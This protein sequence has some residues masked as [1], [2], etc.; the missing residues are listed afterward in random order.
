MSDST[1][2]AVV[3]EIDEDSAFTEAQNNLVLLSQGKRHS[4]EMSASGSVGE[5]GD[6]RCAG[7]DVNGMRMEDDIGDL[8]RHRHRKRAVK[9]TR[10]EMLRR[11]YSTN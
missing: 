5:E 9:D 10:K 4:V 3:T 11:T 2:T 6:P 7:T 8:E 1:P